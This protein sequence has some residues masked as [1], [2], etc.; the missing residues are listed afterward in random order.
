M[1][2]LGG[3]VFLMSE[4][5]LKGLYTQLRRERDLSRVPFLGPPVSGFGVWGL[6]FR[7]K[8]FGFKVWGL[9]F[10]VLD[11]GFEV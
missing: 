9:G 3:W 7:V 1:V 4:A 10:G 5:P 8:G 6:G 11:L 2:I